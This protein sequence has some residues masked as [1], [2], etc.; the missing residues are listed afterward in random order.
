MLNRGTI[1][2]VLA[3]TSTIV[4]ASWLGTSTGTSAGGL[5]LV[6]LVLVLVPVCLIPVI[7][8]CRHLVVSSRME[9]QG[10]CKQLCHAVE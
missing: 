8:W 5:V 1:L 6:V 10:K 4:L 7:R 9:L 3:S 2:H